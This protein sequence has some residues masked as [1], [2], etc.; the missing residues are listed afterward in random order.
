LVTCEY[1]ILIVG[2]VVAESGNGID[3]RNMRTHRPWNQERCDGEVLVM[4]RGELSAEPIAVGDRRDTLGAAVWTDQLRK[5]NRG[6]S[7]CP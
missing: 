1:S 4:C 5:I 6:C 2:N 7:A 3:G